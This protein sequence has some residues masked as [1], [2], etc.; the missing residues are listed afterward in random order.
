MLAHATQPSGR[1]PGTVGVTLGRP[2]GEDAFGEAGVGQVIHRGA[3]GQ[4]LAQGDGEGH[5]L[6]RGQG[7]GVAALVPWHCGRCGVVEGA[8]RPLRSATAGDLRGHGGV[9]RCASHAFAALRASFDSVG[10]R[11]HLPAH[12]LPRAR[13]HR[14]GQCL[15][16]VGAAILLLVGAGL[17]GNLPQLPLALLQILEVPGTQSDP[18]ISIT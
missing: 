5:F 4:I 6:G 18:Q 2:Q 10:F 3:V 1:T 11:R 14:R 8:E 12:R 16:Q 13:L 15:A 9:V 7:R 17:L